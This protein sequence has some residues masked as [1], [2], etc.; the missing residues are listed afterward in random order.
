MKAALVVLVTLVFAFAGC[1]KVGLDS[2]PKESPDHFQL[3]VDS[4][5]NA[6]VLNTRTGDAKKCWQGTPG[7]FS[8]TCYSAI[9]K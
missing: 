3:A 4:T 5:G 6:W 2:H 9:S 1:E 8:P 7:A